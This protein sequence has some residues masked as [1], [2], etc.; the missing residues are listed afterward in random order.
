MRRSIVLLAAAIA[1]LGG[2]VHAGEGPAEWK[3]QRVA[4]FKN[5]LAYFTSEATL[6][7]GTT[8]QLG[9]LPVPVLGTF[10]VSYPDAVKVKALVAGMAD[11]EEQAPAASVV[12]MLSANLG[13]QATVYVGTDPIQG[14][15]VAVQQPSAPEDSGPYLMGAPARRGPSGPVQTGLL[16]L[17]TEEGVVAVNVPVV[18]RADIADAGTVRTVTTR[19]PFLRIELDQPARGR[20]VSVSQLARGMTWAPSYLIDISQP[21]KARFSAK[22]L[23]VNEVLD[24]DAVEVELVTGFPNILFSETNSPI[25]MTQSLADFL[26]SLNNRDTRSRREAIMTQQAVVS[27]AMYFD[28][29]RYAGG[30]PAYGATQEGQVA[31][32]LFFY[33]AG[34]LTLKRGETAMLPLFTEEVPYQHVYTWDIADQLDENERYRPDR[35]DGGP[36]EA[37][38]VWHVCRLENTMGMPW[39]TAPAQF[40]TD[41]RIAG[42]DVCYYTTPGSKTD[43]RVNRALNVVAEQAEY[44]VKRDRNAANFFGYS[45]DRVTVR[46]ELKLTNKVGKDVRAEIVKHLSGEVQETAAG[47][48]DVPTA[49]GLKRVNPRHDLIWELDLGAGDKEELFYVYTVYVRN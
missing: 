38:V 11:V 20:A 41:G 35:R 3:V 23:V 16:L 7:E 18:T 17:R 47:A 4:L 33:P 42:Q 30:T 49:K 45:Y 21:K 43:V 29:E 6:G 46:G 15:I 44:E 27:N 8:V 36:E 40:V 28:R 14:T 12:E 26:N 2:A 31:E 1:C 9:R 13:R 24:L 48:R 25:A 34:R 5:G 39:T 19:A 22:A 10:W 37:P 32:D